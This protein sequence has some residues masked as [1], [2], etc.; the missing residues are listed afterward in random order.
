MTMKSVRTANVG[1]GLGVRAI[2][3]LKED[4]KTSEFVFKT[5]GVE[6]DWNWT[7]SKEKEGSNV[8]KGLVKGAS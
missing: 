4:S 3:I 7:I 6:N 2:S 8:E 5:D 1:S